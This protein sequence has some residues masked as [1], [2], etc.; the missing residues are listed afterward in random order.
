MTDSPASQHGSAKPSDIP[1]ALRLPVQYWRHSLAAAAIV[2]VAA[3]GYALIGVYQK[4]QVEKAEAALG[5]IIT[6]KAG[7]D[8]VAA[9]ETLAKSAPE[10]AKA[11][12]YLELAKT[13]QGLG[14]FTKAA[15][16]FEAVAKSAPTG[17][18][19][20]AGLGEAA[21][22]SRAGQ[23]A[24]AVDV[25]ESLAAKAPKIFAM[26][27]DRQLAVTAEAAG[28]WQ[29]ALAAYERMKADGNV[30]NASFI[31]ARIADLKGK[32]AGAA[33]TNG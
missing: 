19:T 21:A 31:D 26:T 2:L 1:A 30:Q 10:G 7:A 32:T 27:I 33:K 23:D 29:K 9:L 28:Q 16:A 8:R 11:G 14:D 12:I 18:K 5:E 25:L 22:L 24:K 4:G 3:G 13:A 20:I 17:M 6:T 15:S